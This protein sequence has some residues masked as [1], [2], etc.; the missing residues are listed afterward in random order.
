[1]KEAIIHAGFHKAAST[2]IQETLAA[3]VERL[4]GALPV[5]TEM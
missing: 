4:E 3:N 5:L 1:M 2:S